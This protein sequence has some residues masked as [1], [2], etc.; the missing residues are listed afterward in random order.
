MYE[1]NVGQIDRIIRVVL[2]VIFVALV[3]YF[4]FLVSTVGTLEIVLAVIFGILAI[5][6]FVTAYF[7]TCPLWSILK[8]NTNKA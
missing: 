3:V 8:I 6:M 7:A 1:N 5:V 2:G 4:G